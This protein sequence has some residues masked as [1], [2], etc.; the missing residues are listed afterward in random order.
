MARCLNYNW[1]QMTHLSRQSPLA[2]A[3]TS[4]AQMHARLDR[5]PELA[6]KPQTGSPTVGDND[7]VSAC[8]AHGQEET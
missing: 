7:T 4:V 1:L 3:E 8:L 2:N 6:G 5:V